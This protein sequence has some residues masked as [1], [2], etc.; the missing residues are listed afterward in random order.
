MERI[1]FIDPISGETDSYYVLE[2]TVIGG[3][4]YLLVTVEESEDSDA[5][6]MKQIMAEDD[7]C[8]YEILEDEAETE[9]ISKVFMEMLEDTII[10][11]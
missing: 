9:A 11:S 4:T 2:E 3:T 8:T 10:E 6:I 5:Y 7:S 1:D